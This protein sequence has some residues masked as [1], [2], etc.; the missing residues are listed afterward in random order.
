M[1]S[2]REEKEMSTKE[3][4]TKEVMEN[5]DFGSKRPVIRIDAI[6][7]EVPDLDYIPQAF[8]RA[9]KNYRC[10]ETGIISNADWF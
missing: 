3:K 5:I 9:D 1:C 10:D 7:A 6:N 2:E 8:R 4:R